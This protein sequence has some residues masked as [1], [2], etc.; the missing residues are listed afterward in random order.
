MDVEV[1]ILL[2]MRRLRAV[3]LDVGHGAADDL[4]A[5]LDAGKKGFQTLVV[6]GAMP[7]V[8]LA[9]DGMAR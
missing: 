7:L 9:G 8:D 6:G 3:A 4:I 1:G 5:A 2:L